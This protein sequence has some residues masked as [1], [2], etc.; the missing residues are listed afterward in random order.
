MSD[1]KKDAGSEK[2]VVCDHN[3]LFGT[4]IG[5][6]PCQSDLLRLSFSDKQLELIDPDRTDLLSTNLRAHDLRA[7]AADTVIGVARAH[8]GGKLAVRCLLEHKSKINKREL[9]RQLLRYQ[10]GLYERAWSPVVT[11]VINNGAPVDECV[12][13]FR[14]QLEST[15]NAFLKAYDGMVLDFNAVILNLRDPEFQKQLLE[16]GHRSVLG[17]YAMGQGKGR[18]NR[19]FLSGAFRMS[20]QY[21]QETIDRLLLPVL[22][23]LQHY[24]GS[25][26]ID[27]LKDFG[28]DS[29]GESKVMIETLGG[30]E[31]IRRIERQEARQEARQEVREEVRQEVRQEVREEVREEGRQEG[32][33]EGIQE[34]IQEGIEKVAANLLQNGMDSEKVVEVTNLSRRR[35]ESLWQKMNG[36]SKPN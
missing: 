34:G 33:E 35:V 14:D 23:Y 15:D 22:K 9:M 6:Q 30:W 19:E 11:V 26:T 5:W 28:I 7:R 25:G 27:R 13:R 10:T 20:E 16:S 2:P 8:G 36:G 4:L 17:W 12:L 24:H 3:W 1:Q 29:L 21:D 31:T 18:L 32:R